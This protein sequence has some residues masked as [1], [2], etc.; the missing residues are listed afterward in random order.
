MSELIFK[1]A[2]MRVYIATDEDYEALAD[3]CHANPAYDVFLTGQVPV[4]EEWVQDFL[5]DL[6]PQEFGWTA[7]HKLVAKAI[8]GTGEISAIIDVTEDMLAPGIGHIGLFQVAERLHGTGVAH[9]LYQ[10]LESWM[11]HRNTRAIRLGVLEGNPRGM[12]FWTRHEYRETRTRI[13][14]APTGKQH[15][16]HVMYKPLIE[17]SLEQYRQLVPRDHPDTP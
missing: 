2:T 16:S 4:V 8:D 3:F 13:G 15:L 17:M 5:T 9:D 10:A 12:A 14:T 6:P 1:S 7:T 11:V